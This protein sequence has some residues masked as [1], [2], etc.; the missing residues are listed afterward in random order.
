MR[1]D[2]QL[3]NPSTLTSADITCIDHVVS[4]LGDKTGAELSCLAHSEGPWMV[5]RGGLP[6]GGRSN[7]RISLES[8]HAFYSSDAD[9]TKP[10]FRQ[11]P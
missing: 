1:G 10:T 2:L 3:H 5:A 4:R 8:I 7:S 9:L 11:A 6:A